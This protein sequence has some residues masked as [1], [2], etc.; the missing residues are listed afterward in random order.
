MEAAVNQCSIDKNDFELKIKQL[1]IDNDQLLNQ[2]MSQE[3]MHIVVNSVDIPYVN[4]SC[5]DEC[6]SRMIILLRLWVMETIKLEMLQFQRF[7]MWKDYDTASSLWDIFVIRIS[8]LLFTSTPASFVTWKASKTKSWLWHRRLSHLNF[9]YINSL[10]KQGILRGLL[11]LEY[12]KDHLCFA[13]ALSK[14]VDLLVPIAIVPEPT[15]STGTP[16]STTTDQD[17]PLISTSQTTLETPSPF[18]PFGVEEAYHY[19]EVAHIDNNPFVEFLIL[20]PSSEESSTKWIYK[21]KLD[22]LG[23]VLKN[24]AYLVVRGYLQEE[25]IDFEEYFALVS[26]LKAIRVFIAFAIHMNI[27]VYQMDVKNTFLN[28]ILREE[29]YVSQPDGFVDPKNPN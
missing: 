2:I 23:V 22:E 12:Q 24:K 29:V 21:A 16:S 11:K 20:K 18:I 19:I 27:V 14:S 25:G 5:M 26:L 6:Y 10:A 9:Y 1:Q 15:F 13:C 3:I 28:G 17:T 4:K 7:T 8:K